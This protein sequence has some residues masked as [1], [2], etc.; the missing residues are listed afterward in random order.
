MSAAGRT[1]LTTAICGFVGLGA[2]FSSEV[3]YL[4][5]G[6]SQGPHVNDKVWVEDHQA[7]RLEEEDQL[8][9]YQVGL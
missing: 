1:P 9:P 4:F 5:C 7:G 3:C 2:G 6:E 8:D